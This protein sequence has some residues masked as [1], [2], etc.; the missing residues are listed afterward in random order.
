MRRSITGSWLR[1]ALMFLALLLGACASTP[2]THTYADGAPDRQID[3]S[4]IPEPTPKFEPLAA[5]G[6]RS[7]SVYGQPYEI[8]PT[9]AGY[10]ARGVASWYGT[11]FHGKL[12][13]TREPYDMYTFS[14]A[15]KTLPIPSYAQVTNLATGKSIVVRINDRGPFVDNRV[16][17]LSYVAAIKLGINVTGTALV[18]VRTITPGEVAP[19]SA[20]M[21]PAPASVAVA[22]VVTKPPPSSAPRLSG[23]YLQ[24]GAYSDFA[25]ANAAKIDLL[26]AGF[27]GALVER[28]QDGLHRVVLGPLVDRQSAEA[29]ATQLQ[30]LGFNKPGVI[31][32]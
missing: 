16:I 7:Y 6:N 15:H 4:K 23:L 8:L 12:T 5:Y 10:I 29:L 20:A 26:S 11:K 3:I 18:E 22:A 31:A 30:G 17:D 28:G 19:V 9:R 13:S 25:R 1:A 27:S 21:Q 14:A 24:C 32:Q 2:R